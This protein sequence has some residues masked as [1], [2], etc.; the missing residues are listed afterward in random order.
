MTITKDIATIHNAVSEKPAIGKYYVLMVA[1]DHYPVH[2]NDP[3]LTISGL[4]NPVLD[5][6]NVLRIL[7]ERYD[8][9]IPTT[10]QATDLRLIDQRYTEA[11]EP[12][13]VYDTLQYKCMY[14]GNAAHDKILDHIDA[15]HAV[16]GENDAFL[17]YFS[18]HGIVK[19]NSGFI[20]AGNALKNRTG[21][22]NYSE[23]YN[24][25][26][27][28]LKDSKCRDLLLILD[29]CYS[30][31]ISLGK[32]G[33]N[34]SDLFS[35]KVMVS[36]GS[37]KLAFDGDPGEGSPF[38]N[39]LVEA[40]EENSQTLLSLAQIEEVMASKVGGKTKGVQK[41]N[42]G[43]L[44]VDLS[45]K[46]DFYFP[47]N[48]AIKDALPAQQLA[49]SIVKHL[50]FKDQKA[51]FEDH[52]E[53]LFERDF[54]LITTS[55]YN[56][57]VQQ[58]LRTVLFEHTREIDMLNLVAGDPI[59]LWPSSIPD[60]NFWD[61][62]Q[63]SLTKL[64]ISA[65]INKAEII[66]VIVDRLQV[67]PEFVKKTFVIAV[68]YETGLD[69]DMTKLI[70]FC[71]EFME[72]I[73][74]EKRQRNHDSFAKLFLILSELT[75]GNS[76]FEL[77]AALNIPKDAKYGLLNIDR[78]KDQDIN[79]F[80]FDRWQKEATKMMGKPLPALKK[81]DL[82]TPTTK[83]Y[84]ILNLIDIISQKLQVDSGQVMQ[85]IGILK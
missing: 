49:A 18:G 70:G 32:Q 28:Y 13:W 20:L 46:G 63:R 27:N 11:K 15:V 58:L 71:K 16:I 42:F 9:G 53:T 82:F 52:F 41:I 12:I 69:T 79:V 76:S 33:V 77:E 68:G 62:L 65:G 44:P 34:D 81:E 43:P 25:F 19:S 30:E 78:V 51:G 5:A 14:N 8:L 73:E 56:F 24:P 4:N 37:D 36:C 55:A 85:N 7:L 22:I 6:N 31:A 40:L 61:A 45:G 35:R 80:T 17:I 75:P 48:G 21:W 60:G 72:M 26:T 39:A 50:N 1:I 54:H 23:L 67:M 74:A 59:L 2:D 66:K 47:L 84:E 29:C 38:A 57:D 10:D 3:S 83:H 64:Q